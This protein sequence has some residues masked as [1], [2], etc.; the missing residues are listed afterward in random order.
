M[1]FDHLVVAYFFGPPGRYTTAAEV[2]QHYVQLVGG[3]AKAPNSLWMKK[4]PHLV[5]VS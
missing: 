3:W 2:T 4:Y 1:I 5:L